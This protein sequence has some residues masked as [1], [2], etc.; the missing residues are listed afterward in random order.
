[1][2]LAFGFLAVFTASDIS[3]AQAEDMNHFDV[4]GIDGITAATSTANS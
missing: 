4:N 3:N 2:L 1:M